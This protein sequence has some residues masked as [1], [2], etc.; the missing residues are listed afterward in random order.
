M[1]NED[2]VKSLIEKETH[3][4]SKAFQEGFS[5]AALCIRTKVGKVLVWK[6]RLPTK[7]CSTGRKYGSGLL[8]DTATMSLFIQFCCTDICKGHYILA[9]FQNTIQL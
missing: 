2:N 4:Q 8:Q 7:C 3:R 6:H 1:G 9:N 5:I